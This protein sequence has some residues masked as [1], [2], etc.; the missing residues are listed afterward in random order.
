MAEKHVTSLVINPGGGQSSGDVQTTSSFSS[1]SSSSKQVFSTSS[2]TSTSNK[3]VS[4]STTVK[5]TSTTS[6]KKMTMSTSSVTTSSSKNIAIKSSDDKFSDVFSRDFG[7]DVR[8]EME[9]MQLNMDDAVQKARSEMFSLMKL[10]KAGTGTDL[11]K[12]DNTSVLNFLD[13]SHN[14]RLKFNFD[15][16]EFE[17]ETISVKANGN[18]IEVHGVKKSRK[19]EDE[20]SEEFSR[21]YEMPTQDALDPAKVTSSFYKDGI[22]TVELP[23]SAKAVEGQ[24]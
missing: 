21:T 5:K 14:D 3:S 20:T 9:K 1:T 17:S 23:F 18:Q 24:K 2:V 4:S 12:L 10:E 6:V 8:K 19:G 15:V 22:L 13:K 11:V 7:V 16:D